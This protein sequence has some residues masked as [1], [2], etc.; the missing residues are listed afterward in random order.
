MQNI[1]EVF[2]RIQK[3]KKKVKDLKSAYSDALKTVQEYV[4]ATDKLKTLREKKKQIENTIK[5]DFN[6]EFRQ[7]EDLKIDIES[8]TEMLS[9]IVMTQIMKGE[10]VAVTDEYEQSYEPVFKVNF[11]KAN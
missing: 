6:N 4:D 11:K 5:Q 7:M 1:Q 8:D 9:D 10:T 2:V 3:N